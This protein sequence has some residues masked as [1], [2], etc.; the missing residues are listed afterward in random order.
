MYVNN[1]LE[2]CRTSRTCE[3]QR[4]FS[5]CALGRFRPFT[6]DLE[7]SPVTDTLLRL[8]LDRISADQQE[9]Q[10][11][12]TCLTSGHTHGYL[13]AKNLRNTAGIRGFSVAS[14]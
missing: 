9:I 14:C 2:E 3:N 7:V 5:A 6:C 4:S 10:H 13:G 1:L 12:L 11:N 8:Y